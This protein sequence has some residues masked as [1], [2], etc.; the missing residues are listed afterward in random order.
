MLHAVLRLSQYPR[1]VACLLPPTYLQHS[2]L[3]V[4]PKSCVDSWMAGLRFRHVF[5]GAVRHGDGSEMLAKVKNGVSRMAPVS[6]KL[7]KRPPVTIEHMHALHR[8][9]DL[10]RC[11]R[12]G[13]VCMRDGR[14]QRL[15]SPW[16]V[17]DPWRECF[18]PYQ[19]HST[20]NQEVLWAGAQRG[21]IFELPHTLGQDNEVDIILLGFW[22]LNPVIAFRHHLSA[23]ASVPDA[24]PLFTLETA[25]GDWAPMT[26]RWFMERV[27]EIWGGAGLPSSMNGH[28]FRIG[29]ASELL[30]HG[31]PPDVVATQ[32]GGSR[33]PSWNI[34]AGSSAYCRCS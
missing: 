4:C 7:P 5:N 3:P 23:N 14:V 29:R 17:A 13:G 25:A 28:G 8:G 18:L 12:L 33:M 11:L 20:G 10:C 15:K 27:T 32:G 9:L 24:A 30:M 26:K 16:G 21:Q 2:L 19:A 6:A 22:P 31:V 34:G 1:R